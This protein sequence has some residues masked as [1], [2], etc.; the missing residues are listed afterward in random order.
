MIEDSRVYRGVDTGS[1]SGS[2]HLLLKSKV[3]FRLSSKNVSAPRPILDTTKLK[4]PEIKETFMLELTNRFTALQDNDRERK[5]NQAISETET[6]AMTEQENFNPSLNIEKRWIKFRNQVKEAAT[7]ILRI[8][9]KKLKRWISQKTIELSL[10]KKQMTDKH[11]AS[12]KA[13]RKECQK[14]AKADKQAY[15]SNVTC[16]MEKAAARNDSRKLYQLLGES[17]GNKK[18]RSTPTLLSKDNKLL[19][20]K[21]DRIERWLAHFQELLPHQ[22]MTT[23]NPFHPTA[24]LSH[25]PCMRIAISPLQAEKKL[26]MP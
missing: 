25:L 15:W 17:A 24:V 20:S 18:Q 11:F 12:F 5:T 10:R 3:R 14:S 22:K 13:L 23:A 26:Y 9:D 1:K 7:E 6:S 19:T 21:E 2:D 16:E 8:R 4:L